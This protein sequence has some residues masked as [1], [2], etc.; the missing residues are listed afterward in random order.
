MVQQCRLF[1]TVEY[2]R[3]QLCEVCFK[4]FVGRYRY[5]DHRGRSVKTAPRDSR[6]LN[7]KSTKRSW[8]SGEPTRP[9]LLTKPAGGVGVFLSWRSSQIPVVSR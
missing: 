7:C 1:S 4:S 6:F 5:A 8:C 3:G 9:D 2:P